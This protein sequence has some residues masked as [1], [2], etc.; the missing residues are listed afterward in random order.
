M[1]LK[2]NCDRLP[3]VDVCQSCIDAKYTH[4]KSNAVAAIKMRV[5]DNDWRHTAAK[6]LPHSILVGMI[7][8]RQASE[9]RT[10]Y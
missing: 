9:A 8:V 10:Q 1:R 3:V 6:C 5:R 4:I 7:G 2:W